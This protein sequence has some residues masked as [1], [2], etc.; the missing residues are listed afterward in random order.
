MLIFLIAV[1][2]SARVV[3]KEAITPVKWISISLCIGGSAL[4][5]AGLLS[6]ID[7]EDYT[8]SSTNITSPGV[9]NEHHMTTTVSSFF[10][11]IFICVASGFLETGLIIFSKL[12]QNDIAHV[13]ILSF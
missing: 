13:Y 9:E 11:G 12:L 6:T 2:I 10:L 8:V 1:S 7:F 4:V 3:L 5:V